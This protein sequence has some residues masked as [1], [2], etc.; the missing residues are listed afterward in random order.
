MNHTTQQNSKRHNQNRNR[1]RGFFAPSFGNIINEILNSPLHEVVADRPKKYTH[2]AAN[3][4]AEDGK[5]ILSLAIPGLTKKDVSIKID[6]NK[7]V[8]KSETED[9]KEIK[10][11]LKEF[12]FSKF[13]R[14]FTLS[15]NADV[16]NIVASFKNGILE[17]T[18][19]VLEE[20]GPKEVKIG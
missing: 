18:I 3:V 8:V 5:Y 11:R 14:A 17:V 10:Y 16:E 12:N 2:P 6:K 1:N 9:N 13:E 15:E 4:I 19:P 20:E 7:L